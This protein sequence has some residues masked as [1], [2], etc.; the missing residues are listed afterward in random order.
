[1]IKK[2]VRVLVGVTGMLIGYLL[3]K[4]GEYGLD[5]LGVSWIEGLSK[6][7][8]HLALASFAIIF[9]I[10][11]YLAAP[12]LMRILFAQAKK[13]SRDLQ[14]VPG[15][16]IIA[17]AIGLIAGLLIAFLVTGTLDVIENAYAR[18][19]LKVLI[20]IVLGFVGVVVAVAKSP[21]ITKAL[22]HRQREP[23]E[24]QE[25][26]SRQIRS[27]KKKSSAAPKVLDTS[28]IIDGRIEG[29]LK[30]GFIEG[31]IVIP[32]VVLVE[33]RHIADSSDSLKRARGRQG[34]EILN[35]IRD[36]YGVEV[37]NT[38]TEKTLKDVA[39][40]DVRILKLAQLLDGK[41]VTNDYNLNRV[42]GIN[43]VSVLNINELANCL[44]TAV[45]PG[46]SLTLELV[47]EG[48]EKE[49]AVGYLDDGTMIVVE[50]GR[51]MLGKTASIRVT[52]V[53]QTSVGRMIFGRLNT[54]G[55]KV[56]A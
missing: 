10:V 56:S 53:L 11:F 37:V 39:E 49:Q 36:E 54:D 14:N 7:T 12:S 5:R 46:E 20:Y 52:S 42:A 28:V 29:I 43:G 41:V 21:E 35:R 1:M 9:F 15:Y 44:K 3:G 33:L 48:K 25:V 34:L 18:A 8:L 22:T 38:D 2:L 47:K 32:D 6:N 40:V 17:G 27:V 16:R 4:F 50:D 55:S 13:L 26:Q 23:K 30:S 19:L 24:S 31:P 45:L 51:P